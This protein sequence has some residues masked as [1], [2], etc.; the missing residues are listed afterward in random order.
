MAI[1]II[2]ATDKNSA[3]GYKNKLLFNINEDM[4]R[5]K[6]LT[7]GNSDVPNI[8]VMGRK[9]FESL[10]KPLPNRINVV[11]TKNKRYEAPHGVFV[12][13]SVEKII[14]HYYSGEQR[15]DI[16]VIGGS[17]IYKLFLPYADEVHL[18]H[19]DKEA[20]KVDTYFPKDLLKEYFNVDKY[21]EWFFSEEEDCSY[22]FVNYIK[23]IK[24]E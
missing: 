4:K 8:V 1:K 3:I 6:E 10:P 9:T 19:I 13:D 12:F 18:T 24:H 16:F 11:L 23:K 22:C 2:A 15:R 21:S 5:F 7:K 17:Q 14:N 20:K